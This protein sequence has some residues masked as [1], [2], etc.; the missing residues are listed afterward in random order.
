M[1]RIF[2]LKKVIIAERLRRPQSEGIEMKLLPLLLMALPLTAG[3]VT[4]E[5]GAGVTMYRTGDGTWYQE[6]VD[7]KLRDTPRAWSIGLTGDL[8][9]AEYWGVAWHLDYVNLGHAS[10]SCDCTP[11]DANYDPKSHTLIRDDVPRAHY[12]GSGYAHGAVL[13]LEPYLTRNRWRF[14]AEV[15]VMAYLPIWNESVTSWQPDTSVPAQ[16]LQLSTP[17]AVR[18]A[19]VLGASIGRD[20][21]TVSY[22]HYFLRRVNDPSVPPLWNDADVIEYKVRF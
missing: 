14:G 20:K 9:S 19:L 16:N 12:S 4:I 18:P 7:H 8:Y 11:I 2:E 6:G 5:G 21:W 17:R 3:A 10:A 1:R 13:S 22:R 15:G